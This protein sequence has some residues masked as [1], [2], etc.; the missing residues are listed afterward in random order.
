MQKFH[1]NDAGD[2]IHEYTEYTDEVVAEQRSRG[3]FPS[4]LETALTLLT[5]CTNIYS[6]N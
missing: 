6:N 2:I 4:C 1:E 5:Q 3:F